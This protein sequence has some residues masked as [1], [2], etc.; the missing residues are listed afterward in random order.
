MD[1]SS[2]QGWLDRYVAAWKSYDRAEIESL[3]ASE[4][5]YRYHPYDVED[6]IVR[7]RD[8]IVSDWVEP[9]GAASTRDAAGTYDARYEPYAVDGDRAVAIGWSKYWTDESRS[10]LEKT[11]DN[12]FLLRF[13]HDGRCLEFTEYFM[14]RPDGR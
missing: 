12:V 14:K 11:Y 5:T 7:G 1:R 2:V 3:F 9:D 4:A 10:T 6:E 8:A 13:D